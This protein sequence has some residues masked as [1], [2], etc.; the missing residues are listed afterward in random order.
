[1]Y[2]T[3]LRAW[4]AARSIYYWVLMVLVTLVIGILSLPFMIF[5]LRRPMHMV[6]FVWGRMLTWLAGIQVHV[7]G[8]EHLHR[9]GPIVLI[10][11]H[12]SMVDIIVFYTILDI[13]FAWMA[14]ASLFKL[15]FI[16]WGMTAAGYIP[17]ER[18]DRR[19]SL[20]SLYEAAEIVK[21]GRSVIVFPEGTRGHPDG[22]MLP[23]K[24][25]GFI[26]AK[27]A[28]V[29]VQPVTIHGANTVIPPRQKGTRVQRIYPGAVRVVIHPPLQPRVYADMSPEDLSEHVRGIIQAPL[30]RLR[31]EVAATT[32]PR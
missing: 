10:A 16:G 26:L 25:G 14:K 27:R 3:L 31:R 18:H 4:T 7:E 28:G 11:N 12:Q 29:V 24:K 21:R 22:S 9:I 8:R 2:K 17:V 20:D 23:F 5:R 30:A 15:P 32:I 19:R 6:G 13:P 1:M